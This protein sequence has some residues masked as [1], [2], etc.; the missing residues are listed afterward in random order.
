MSAQ[1]NYVYFRRQTYKNF[2]IEPKFCLNI[3]RLFIKK[4]NKRINIPILTGNSDKNT[5][6]IRTLS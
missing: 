1:C 3:C 4:I 5:I 6:F 2:M